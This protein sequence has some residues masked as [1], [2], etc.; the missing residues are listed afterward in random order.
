MSMLQASGSVFKFALVGIFLTLVGCG[1]V[2][3]NGTTPTVVGSGSGGG[4]TT[5]PPSQNPSPQPSPALVITQ[6]TSASG[7]TTTSNS[8]TLKGAATSVVGTPS[9]TW[10]N[11]RG[12][13]GNIS[14][15][16]NSGTCNW[17]TPGITLASGQN[18]LTLKAVA[19]GTSFQDAVTVTYNVPAPTPT[20]TPNPTPPPSPVGG[21]GF[22]GF[23][24]GVSGGT[25]GTVYTV[26]NLNDSGA[27]SLREAIGGSNR[28]V[29][30][31]VAGTISLR[32]PLNVTGPN[33]TIDGLS[34][35][36][37]G[38]TLTSSSNTMVIGG[39]QSGA[40]TSGSNII[41]QGLR[42][43]NGAAD[44]I[45]IAYNAHD[46]VIDHNSFSGAGDGEVD[47]TEGAYN[48][49]ISYN[50]FA[51]NK[52]PGPCLLS[53]DSSQVSYHHNIFYEN[54]YRNPIITSDFNRNY[55]SGPKHTGLVADVRYNV[56]WG[57]TL[58]TYVVS[59]G[60][61]VGTANIVSNLYYNH[62]GHPA[63]N[64]IRDTYS[65]STAPADAYI[66]G[67]VA[68][69]RSVGSAY[70]HSGGSY[71]SVTS[72]NSMNNHAEYNA[73]KISGPSPTDQQGRKDEWTKAKSS[74]GLI[75]RFP[76]D[77]IDS[78]VRSTVSIPDLSVIGASWNQ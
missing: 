10:S 71:I 15:S 56:V 53:Y 30:F 2:S 25:G 63:S 18:V 64:A 32:S 76:D 1:G 20:P 5:P 28:I 38:M 14:L 9:A 50:I 29:R 65:S 17:S 69:E 4:T 36:S 44:A 48:V 34:A 40:D 77:S 26:T 59:T 23:G 13:S 61:S 27:G 49:T 6:P 39:N 54:V 19:N 51:R 72:T 43:R 78:E 12:G 7:Y 24:A 67:N 31:G 33:I 11:N 42:F 60:G 68:V 70:S 21:A 46:V 3:N 41:V 55:S 52:G 74:A 58:G 57:F 73:P 37:P 75:S 62:D 22:E 16:C 45:Q 8:I 47:V 35:P 66:A